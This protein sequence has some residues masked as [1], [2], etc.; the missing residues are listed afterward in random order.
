MKQN[1]HTPTRSRQPHTRARTHAQRHRAIA[2]PV[3]AGPD[4][5]D[6]A[7]AQV[8]G[9][10]GAGTCGADEDEFGHRAREGQAGHCG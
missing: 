7:P 5:G 9:W 4:A 1:T 10:R 2:D 6:G 8:S 3:R